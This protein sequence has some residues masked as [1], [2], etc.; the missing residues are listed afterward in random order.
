MSLAELLHIQQELITAN[1]IG[2]FFLYE[3]PE[4]LEDEFYP[5]DRFQWPEGHSDYPD[6]TKNDEASQYGEKY[7]DSK[8]DKYLSEDSV[9]GSDA[10]DGRELEIVDPINHPVHFF[11]DRPEGEE[12]TSIDPIH[13]HDVYADDGPPS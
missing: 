13:H 4:Y 10:E 11:P 8:L 1:E 2:E 12:Y 6:L 9:M 3:H 7:A 5:E